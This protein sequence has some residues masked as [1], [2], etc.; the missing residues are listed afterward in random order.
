LDGS[1]K[2]NAYLGTYA[3]DQSS[4]EASWQERRTLY[5]RAAI[6]FEV[7]SVKKLDKM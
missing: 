6:S 4:A 3:A 1:S 2:W 5:A 7:I